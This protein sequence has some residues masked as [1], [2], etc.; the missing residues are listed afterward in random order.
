[1][2]W[3][4]R[5]DLSVAF[6]TVDHDIPVCRLKHTYGLK[7]TVLAWIKDYI[8]GRVQSVSWDGLTSAPCRVLSDVPQGSVLECYYLSY[9]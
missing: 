4:F 7:D 2:E 8:V 1:M 5:A 6:D 9:T 3:P